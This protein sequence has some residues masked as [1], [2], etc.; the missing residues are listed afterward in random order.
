MLKPLG[1][2]RRLYHSSRNLYQLPI[3]TNEY[4]NKHI[5]QI[6]YKNDPLSE[7]ELKFRPR[8]EFNSQLVPTFK[9]IKIPPYDVLKTL[10]PLYKQCQFVIEIRDV[11]TPFTSKNVMFDLL[12]LKSVTKAEIEE[13]NSKGELSTPVSI[14][15]ML[16]SQIDGNDAYGDKEGTDEKVRDVE[17]LIVYTFGDYLNRMAQESPVSRKLVADYK[18]KLN[19]YHKQ[20]KENYIII[21]G[22]NIPKSGLELRTILR[23]FYY[24]Y[25][26]SYDNVL[27]PIGF[28][29][30][31]TG[32]PNVGKSNVIN[33]MK[34]C[35]DKKEKNQIR[36]VVKSRNFSG[37]T[38]NAS[39]RIKVDDFLHG[40]YLIDTPGLSMPP[41][42]Y[43]LDMRM[44]L[45]MNSEQITVHGNSDKSLK[46][47][48]I[49]E[50]MELDFILYLINLMLK[51]EVIKNDLQI[52]FVNDVWE[53]LEWYWQNIL[54]N[55]IKN[56]NMKR[57]QFEHD[58]TSRSRVKKFMLSNTTRKA[59]EKVENT[60]HDIYLNWQN[61]AHHLHHYY[62]KKL[63]GFHIPCYD[64]SF[65]LGVDEGNDPSLKH[66]KTFIQNQIK[67]ILKSHPEIQIELME[68]SVEVKTKLK[69]AEE[70]KRI[71]KQKKVNHLSPKFV[72]SIKLKHEKK[73]KNA[74]M[75]AYNKVLFE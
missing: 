17:K 19:F 53:L 15:D 22:T 38:R 52:P 71:K 59:N 41:V 12:G 23:T 33:I 10:L 45:A 51:K 46:T 74:F 73:K 8:L 30:L 69:I 13:R 64:I 20:M 56:N 26:S 49:D 48:A 6:T 61:I 39:G 50:I 7:E 57:S 47:S 54:M 27:S 25:V 5:E 36:K 1:I 4:K 21:D 44:A 28:N 2:Q 9:S 55:E 14:E 11:R 62:L 29:C 72:D 40:I 58:I 66:F 75:R 18:K 16:M 3:K 65:W 37:T 68:A 63:R 35:L 34:H 67:K 43:D 32:I 70:I 31:I 42:M 24:R 60:K